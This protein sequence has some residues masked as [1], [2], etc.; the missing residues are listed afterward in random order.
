MSESISTSWQDLAK[1]PQLL[2]DAKSGLLAL[3]S[4]L[5]TPAAAAASGSPVAGLAIAGLGVEL[6][7]FIAQTVKA[8]D[9]DIE[10]MRKVSQNYQQNEQNLTQ[11]VQTGANALMT[12]T[13]DPDWCGTPNV[14]TTPGSRPWTPSILPNYPSPFGT[15]PTTTLPLRDVQGR[16]DAVRAPR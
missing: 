8:I 14:G 7:V 5:S 16:P 12:R 10:G 3:Q 11:L 13:A 1:L 6:A 4:L 15:V 9:D 2:G